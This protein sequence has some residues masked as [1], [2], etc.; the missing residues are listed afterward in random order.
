MNEMVLLPVLLAYITVKRMHALVAALSFITKFCLPGFIFLM[1][2]L[3]SWV[4]QLIFYT[5]NRH[6]T[7]YNNF[8]EVRLLYVF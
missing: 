3:F 4:N 7:S 2:E 5:N 8:F 6:P 1:N